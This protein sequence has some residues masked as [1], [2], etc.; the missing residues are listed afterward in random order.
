MVM[1]CI[2]LDPAEKMTAVRLDGHQHLEGALVVLRGIGLP[3]DTICDL[4]LWLRTAYGRPEVRAIKG[5][6]QPA[7]ASASLEVTR[8]IMDAHRDC[9]SCYLK[10]HDATHTRDTGGSRLMAVNCPSN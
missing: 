9:V 1:D 8:R 3:V 4:P 10:I 5:S 6:T 2:L 7:I